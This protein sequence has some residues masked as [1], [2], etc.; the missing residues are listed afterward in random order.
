MISALGSSS[1]FRNSSTKGRQTEHCRAGRLAR[2]C[3]SSRLVFTISR[4]IAPAAGFAWRTGRCP[5]PR[6]LAVGSR[7]LSG[8]GAPRSARRHPLPTQP[9]FARIGHHG[10]QVAAKLV[11]AAQAWPDLR[12]ER[13]RRWSHIRWDVRANLPSRYGRAFSVIVDPNCHLYIRRSSPHRMSR[14][15]G[16]DGAFSSNSVACKR[17]CRS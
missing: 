5:A 3:G 17:R 13:E 11:Q 8:T 10:S 12:G 9:G 15:R 1:I 2:Q 4:S 6:A 16:G 14:R 7:L